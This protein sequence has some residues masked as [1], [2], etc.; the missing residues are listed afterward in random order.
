M[1]EFIIPW[2][3]SGMQISADVEQIK[4][5]SSLFNVIDETGVYDLISVSELKH[6]KLSV[7]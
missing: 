4:M 7:H 5:A 3:F 2:V 1:R 6:W